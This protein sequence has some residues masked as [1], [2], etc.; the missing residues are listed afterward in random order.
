MFQVKKANI[1]AS[2]QAKPSHP[3]GLTSWGNTRHSASDCSAA[4]A[5]ALKSSIRQCIS[6]SEYQLRQC[7]VALRCLVYLSV[8]DAITSISEAKVGTEPVNIFPILGWRLA[9][10][11]RLSLGL[12]FTMEVC[13]IHLARLPAKFPKQE[14]QHSAELSSVHG[15]PNKRMWRAEWTMLR[16]SCSYTSALNRNTISCQYK[17]EAETSH[18]RW[19]SKEV[20]KQQHLLIWGGNCDATLARRLGDLAR[21]N[22]GPLHQ[23]KHST[24][25]SMRTIY[26]TLELSPYPS[27]DGRP[28]VQSEQL[29]AVYEVKNQALD[30][31]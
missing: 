9:K 13:H 28:S 17:I 16:C 23:R 18:F 24:T 20:V 12:F 29:P 22:A 19:Q 15:A 27:K 26:P 4:V 1:N 10:Q 21:M 30:R 6:T 14:T 3:Y 8:T 11:C 2:F 7:V 25:V 31:G 5:L